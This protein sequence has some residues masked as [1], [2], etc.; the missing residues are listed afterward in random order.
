MEK[1]TRETLTSML[2]WMRQQAIY[3]HRQH[4]WI[5]A[6]AETVRKNPQL[7]ADLEQ[8]PSYDQGPRQDLQNIDMLLQNI[9]ALIQRLNRA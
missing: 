3:L 2:Q 1:E 8:H 4:G 9:D 6:L 7:A 5:V